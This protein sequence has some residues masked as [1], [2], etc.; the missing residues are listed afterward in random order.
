MLILHMYTGVSILRKSS[1]KLIEEKAGKQSPELQRYFKDESFLQM[2]ADEKLTAE[3]MEGKFM[4]YK[5]FTEGGSSGS[6]ILSQG[7][8]EVCYC[9][10]SFCRLYVYISSPCNF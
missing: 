5:V 4:A 7:G 8:K 10:I 2:L 9:R 6:P 1:G 3:D